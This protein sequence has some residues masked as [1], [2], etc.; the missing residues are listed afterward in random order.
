MCGNV[1]QNYTS[2]THVIQSHENTDVGNVK[3]Q[4]ETLFFF[5]VSYPCCVEMQNYNINIHDIFV[6]NFMFIRLYRL[7]K[8]VQ[9]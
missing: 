9:I 6:Q 4:S 7:Y 1:I 5:Q 3:A 8:V 2:T